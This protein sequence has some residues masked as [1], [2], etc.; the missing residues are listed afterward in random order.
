MKLNDI[1]EIM[2]Y[3][4]PPSLLNPLFNALC[5]LFDREERFVTKSRIITA[6]LLLFSWEECQQLLM[7]SKFLE[8]LRFFDRDNVPGHKVRKLEKMIGESTNFGSITY[9]S[10]ATEP[11]SRW[12]H[13]LVDYH[14]VTMATEPLKKKLTLAEGTLTNV[15]FQM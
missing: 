4:E 13:A 8:S 15:R 7:T 14:K 3:R 9:G 11:L 6:M 5:M 12:L 1:L 2:K 10:K